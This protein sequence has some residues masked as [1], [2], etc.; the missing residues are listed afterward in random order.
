[1]KKVRT[2][3]TSNN[4]LLQFNQRPFSEKVLDL[5]KVNMLLEIIQKETWQNH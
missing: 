2:T 4:E 3:H 5:Q 1:M